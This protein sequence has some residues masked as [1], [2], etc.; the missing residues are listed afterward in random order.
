LIDTHVH[1]LSR[2][3]DRDREDVIKRAFK[4]GNEFLVEIGTDLASSERAVELT[5]SFD[6]IYASVGVHPHDAKTVDDRA[7]RRLEE[8]AG[9]PR[10]VAVGEAGLDFYRDLSPRDVQ[11]RVFIE[12]IALAKKKKLP[13]VVHIRDAYREALEILEKENATD[14]GGVLHCFAGNEASADRAI[15]LGFF[16]GFGGTI[17]YRHSA[18]RRLIPTLPLEDVVLET[19]CPYLTPEP[20]RG[21]RNEPAYV[22]LALDEIARLTKTS[23]EKVEEAT[24]GNARELFQL[25]QKTARS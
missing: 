7:L 19:D 18:G 3:F 9:D 4:A 5:K 11:K 22:R 16:L 6:R 1:L 8:L 20:H 13:L 23:R 21:K 12:L 24:D 10:V 14:V 25:D 2:Q 17:T 15:G